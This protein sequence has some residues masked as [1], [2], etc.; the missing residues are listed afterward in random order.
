[1][2]WLIT[3]DTLPKRSIA[4]SR[5]LV[6]SA[7]MTMIVTVPA[8]TEEDAAQPVVLQRA[9]SVNADDVVEDEPGPVD[10]VVQEQ[11]PSVAAPAARLLN[12]EWY[13]SQVD[14][15]ELC[16]QL[17]LNNNA[18]ENDDGNMATD[19]T[20]H[21]KIIETFRESLNVQDLLQALATSPHVQHASFIVATPL[22]AE[23]ATTLAQAVQSPITQLQSLQICRLG[24]AGVD[25]LCDGLQHNTTLHSLRLTFSKHAK[26]KLTSQQVVRLLQTFASMK[27]LQVIKLFGL[28][29]D[30]AALQEWYQLLTQSSSQLVDI[31]LTCCTLSS[32][33]PLARAIQ[34]ANVVQHLDLSMCSL[35]DHAA[36]AILL[37]T[38]SLRQ[39]IVSEN[40]FGKT[41]WHA[42]EVAQAL[43]TNTTLR[44]LDLGMNPLSVAFAK[45]LERALQY[46]TTL[47]ELWLF[48]HHPTIPTTT[49][50]T[51]NLAST[52]NGSSRSS[53]IVST[54][55]R[56][57]SSRDSPQG[58]YDEGNDAEDDDGA[59]FARMEHL[60]QLNA[61]GRGWLRAKAH[62]APAYVPHLFARTAPHLVF[63][64]LQDHPMA[65][66]AA[67]AASSSCSCTS[68][69]A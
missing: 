62:K 59:V 7:T 66:L 22:T 57:F 4:S 27:Q 9:L 17:R 33:L 23:Q 13:D 54:S 8:A 49:T 16:R 46:N 19:I 38:A 26:D 58:Y 3:I 50:T 29:F 67:A 47:C 63:G 10:S 41:T 6:S 37:Q 52:T 15:D 60:V 32:L 1:V 48:H 42:K 68:A 28:E 5:S 2:G 36:L 12:D 51:T 61:A 18:K 43:Q 24:C 40:H 56:F 31:R 45:H 69:T 44:T 30:A 39:L 34:K 53:T 25:P 64:L 11:N 55:Q 14:V 20:R 65:L 35:H 21:V